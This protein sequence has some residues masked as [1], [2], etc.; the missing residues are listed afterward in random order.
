MSLDQLRRHRA[1]DI[2]HFAWPELDMA[3]LSAFLRRTLPSLRD[4]RADS[5]S[6]ASRDA[7]HGFDLDSLLALLFCLIT[8]THSAYDGLAACVNMHVLD[9]H[10]LLCGFALQFLHRFELFEK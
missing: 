4:R 1:S 2:F 5:R 10:F 9:G 7:E 6:Q 3:F 8:S